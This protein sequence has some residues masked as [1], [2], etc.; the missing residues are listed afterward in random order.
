[1]SA[2]EIKRARAGEVELAYETFGDPGDPPVLL[3]MGLATQ[4]LG[5]PDE[6][7]AALAERGHCVV[8]FDNRDIGLSTHLHDAPAPDALAAMAGDTSSASYTLSD[9]ARDTAGLLDALELDARPRRRRLDGRDDRPDAG[10]RA[11]ASGCGPSPRSCRR[12]A[13]RP[14]AARPRRRSASCWPRRRARARRRSPRTLS[15]VP[16]DRLARLRA[17]RGGAD[18]AR[19]AA[20]DRAHDPLG[21]GRQ[22]L[23]ILASGDRTTGLGEVQVPTLVIHGADDPL[24]NVSGGE[25]TAAAV[26][27]AELVVLE[28]MGHD[29]PAALLDRDRGP[30]RR[31]RGARVSIHGREAGLSFGAGPL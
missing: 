8:R 28:G 24:V 25:A 11:P 15:T 19:R 3:V 1:M 17:R 4:M 29:L 18:R 5:W 26:P 16:R 23:A 27:G 13:T 7:C 30:D 2:T 20:F 31:A 10:D 14:S 6:F 21:V 9:M 22:L 12:P